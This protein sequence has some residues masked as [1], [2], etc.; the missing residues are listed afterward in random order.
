MEIQYTFKCVQIEYGNKRSSTKRFKN[1][2][3]K[4]LG[5]EYSHTNKSTEKTIKWHDTQWGRTIRPHK[6]QDTQWGR[7]M[8]TH[9]WHDTKLRRTMRICNQD[10][11][12]MIHNEDTQWGYTMRKHNEATKMTWYTM[13][14]HNE[15]TQMTRYTMRTTNS[16]KRRQKET[17]ITKKER[18]KST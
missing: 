9:K 2:S 14:A 1:V 7:T 11:H 16:T 10:T 18:R 15:D 4:L 12:D 6:W 8:R 5:R 13:R 3:S 17:E